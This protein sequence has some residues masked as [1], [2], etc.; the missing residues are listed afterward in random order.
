LA[1]AGQK[2]KRLEGCKPSAILDALPGQKKEGS[3]GRQAAPELRI[4]KP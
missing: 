3:Q 4:G 1:A 2:K